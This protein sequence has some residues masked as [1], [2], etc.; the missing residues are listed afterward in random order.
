[1]TKQQKEIIKKIIPILETLPGLLGF[2]SVFDN[3]DDDN[4]SSIIISIE[5]KN[6]EISIGCIIN[7]NVTS[8]VMNEEIYNALNFHFKKEKKFIL[9]KLN[10]YIKGVK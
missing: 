1:M 10:I 3:N 9:K 6:L 5:D 4:D 8:K 7:R 2:V